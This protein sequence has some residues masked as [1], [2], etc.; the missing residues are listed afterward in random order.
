MGYSDEVSKMAIYAMIAFLD[1]SV[2]NSKDPVFAD[3]ARRPLQEEM[4]G[5]HFAGEYFFRNVT[6]LLSRPESTETADA[7]ELHALCL[8]LGYRGR[9]AF[10][11]T[12]EIDS[13]LHRI[14]DKIMRIRG[15]YALFRPAEPPAVPPVAASDPWVRRLQFAAIAL[16]VLT[17]LA[18]IGY[19]LILSQSMPTTARIAEPAALIAC[20]T[21]SVSE[22]SL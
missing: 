9:F 14:R 15:G 8:Q 4:F 12:S 1:E 18:Y 7:L 11:D 5:G 16:A 3:W 10:G 21:Q 20:Q 6:D 19:L 2:L 13:I 17:L 22:M